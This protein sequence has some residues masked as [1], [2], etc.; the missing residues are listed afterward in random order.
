M[1]QNKISNSDR[2]RAV[3][4]AAFCA[5]LAAAAVGLCVAYGRLHALWLEQCVITDFASQVSITDGRMV[6][7]D[8]V[9]SEFG[10]RNGA[11]LACIDFE[12][13]RR[14]L[15]KKIPN[16]REVTI[17]RHL[18]DRVD[19]SIEERVP[20]VRLGIRGQNRDSGRVADSEGVVFISSNGTQTL[21]LIREAAEPGTPKGG[22]LGGLA[23][24]ALKL[25]E[26]CR[27]GFRELGVIE[28]DVSKT[29]YI[30]IVLAN[31]YT[32]AKIAW[33]G[34]DSPSE[35]TQPNLTKQLRHLSE[36]ISSRVDPQIR[37]WDA[38]QPGYVYGNT[39]KGFL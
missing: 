30:T 24:A 1:K 37:E 38:T 14:A 10:L 19:I 20:V 32:R 25:I 23:L 8:V 16:L 27:S 29:D 39:Q 33:E 31:D 15:L 17:V 28:A 11:N 9:A 3:K 34:M 5:L 12:E 2:K 6:R 4:T 21:P 36:A 7:S 35:A 18:P 22:T 26:T 13:R